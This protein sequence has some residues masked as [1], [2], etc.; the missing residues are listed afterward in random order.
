MSCRRPIRTTRDS[1]STID[2]ADFSKADLSDADLTEAKLNGARLDKADLSGANLYRADLTGCWLSK[3]VLRGTD[4]RE[5]LFSGSKVAAVVYE[6][7]KRWIFKKRQALMRGKCLGIQGLDTCYGDAMFRRDAA[8][9][10][11]L[12]TLEHRWK[13]KW[14]NKWNLLFGLWG[15]INYGRC[16]TCVAVLASPFPI[17]F[18]FIYEFWPEMLDYGGSADT[19]FTPFYYSI[20]TFTTLGFG[21]VTP[22][23]WE[24][25]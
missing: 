24:G 2:A 17:I 6:P 14:W 5:A 8:D 18:G 16:V 22:K 10:D 19:W 20:V 4:L 23:T 7:E 15:W 12:D 21:D 11:Y 9:Q 25:K 13:D 3:T 1:G